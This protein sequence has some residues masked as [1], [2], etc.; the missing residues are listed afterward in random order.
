MDI[1]ELGQNSPSQFTM[2]YFDHVKTAW[3][4][5]GVKKT[6][7]RSNEYQLID[8]AEYF[9]N[10]IDTIKNPDYI[11]TNQDILFCRIMTVSISKIDFQIP[12]P[13]KYGGGTAEFWMFDV[14][15][16][17]GEQKKW[18]KVFAGIQAILFLIAASDFD[19]KLREDSRVNRL[20]E[21]FN[22]FK[23]MYSNLYVKDA[24]MIVFLNKQDVFQ[25]K[26]EQG[27]KL[28]NYFPEYKSFTPSSKEKCNTEYDKAKLFL[29]LK[30]EGIA[31]TPII[32]EN[33]G[34]RPGK[35]VMEELPQRDVY[36]HYTIAT[37]T[38]N[39]RKVF[40]SVHESI[41]QQIVKEVGLL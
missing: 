22:V 34:L 1:L 31:R 14:G 13:K 35:N 19:L 23:S 5:E 24:A 8:C 25:K 2:E 4:D 16:Q 36:I 38:N 12:V 20:E 32:I 41:L 30:I 27:R 17:R 37:D 10:R 9:L 21:S 33:M 26:I 18:I 11:P 29:K 3:A 7:E 28:E 6:F 40:D 39:I 15:G